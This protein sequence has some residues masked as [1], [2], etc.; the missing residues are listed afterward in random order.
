LLDNYPGA[1]IAKLQPAGRLVAA[2][3][4]RASRHAAASGR[5]EGG[6]SMVDPAVVIFAIKAAVKLGQATCNVLVDST[7]ARPLLLPVGDLA[8]SIAEAEAIEFFDRPENQPLVGPRGPYHGFD[9][10]ALREAYCTIQ[11]VADKLGG[12]G[13]SADAVAII[14]GLH[15]FEQQKQAFGPRPAWQ[16]IL[17]TVVEIGV[18]YFVA[19]P[20]AMGKNSS[21]QRIVEA[22]LIGIKDIPFADGK[23]T[24]IVGETLL[25]G[26]K[27]LGDNANLISNDARV[28]VL[29]GGVTA[30]LYDEMQ[31]A[32]SNLGEVQRREDLFKRITASIIRG[33]AGVVAKNADLFIKGDDQATGAVRSTLTEMLQGVRDQQQLFSNDTLEVLFQTALTATSANAPL[34]TDKKL[35]QA[36]L[37]STVAAL[38][39]ADGSRLFAAAAVAAITQAALQTVGE[40]AA[41]L[42]DPAHPERQV[43]AEAVGAIAR[44]LATDLA[45]TPVKDLLSTPNLVALT[46]GMFEELGKHPEQLLARVN[47]DARRTVLTQVI[48]SVAVALGDRPGALVNGATFVELTRT[49][50]V[51]TL[52]NRDKL[53]DLQ[54]PDPRTNL[55]FKVLAGLAGEAGSGR[56]PRR[57]LDRGVFLAMAT[58]VLRA[59]SDDLDP[60]K[61]A[62]LDLV[63]AAMSAALALSTGVLR[64]RIN[65]E[66]L[67]LLTDG[68]LRRAL[69]GELKLTDPQAVTTTALGLL[70]GA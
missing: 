2:M 31:G 15:T 14:A 1:V 61:P 4:G 69:L 39:S 25:A 24:D 29:L 18:D 53:L 30:S 10:K 58:R 66:N 26:L 22:F 3:L 6:G 65:G 63:A 12:N 45:G 41:M 59:A 50:L 57:L 20:P 68:L 51:I 37:R 21:A 9:G 16:R 23:S 62:A 43:I 35:V 46:Q 19:N 44:G 60:S 64:H 49:V 17:G 70:R 36:I 48:A 38:T 27:A 47:N 56:D 8:G 28:H 7:Q 13:S 54:S 42:V 67:P 5:A 32:G 55:V 52:K 33:G 11:K 34:F 40:N